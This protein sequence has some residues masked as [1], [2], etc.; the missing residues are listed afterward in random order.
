VA[1]KWTDL[2]LGKHYPL[3][4]YGHDQDVSPYVGT[5]NMFVCDANACASGSFIADMYG[6]KEASPQYG[7][8]VHDV[9]DRG[10]VLVCAFTSDNTDEIKVARNARNTGSFTVAFCPYGTDGDTS[11]IRL[12]KE[13]DV[14][15]NSYCDESAGVIAVEGF[16]EKVSPLG[17]ICGNL[18]HW[19]LMARWTDH[20]ARRGEM[21]YYWKGFHEEGGQ[22]YDNA[23]LPVAQKR[24]Y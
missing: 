13:V 23:M 15:F 19:M 12:F 9:N 21:P 8:Y 20:M 7:L 24:G 11:G 10:I 17:G 22:E 18:I 4:L 14:A 3:L 1:E 2:V 5:R 16:K 6:R